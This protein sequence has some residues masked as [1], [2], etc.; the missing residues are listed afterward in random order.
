[1]VLVQATWCIALHAVESSKVSGY[2]LGQE[3]VQGLL[4]WTQGHFPLLAVL[5]AE[6]WP[7]GLYFSHLAA[8][9]LVFW[10]RWDP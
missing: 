1:M 6:Q 9:S 7:A 3:P 2:I 8:A 10:K 4:S 5:P